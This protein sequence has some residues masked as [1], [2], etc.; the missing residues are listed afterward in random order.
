MHFTHIQFIKIEII[1]VEKKHKSSYG[2][3]ENVLFFKILINII[4]SSLILNRFISI[5]FY[6]GFSQD[7]ISAFK[8][9]LIN[10]N[11]Q[12]CK[13]QQSMGVA[14]VITTETLA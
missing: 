1:V 4:F 3:F 7:L 2:L 9:T 10:N 13:I 8:Q 14:M 12:H 11:K 6:T 5:L